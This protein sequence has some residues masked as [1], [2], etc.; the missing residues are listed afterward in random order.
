MYIV[1]SLVGVV[2]FDIKV[3]WMSLRL[4]GSQSQAD[5]FQLV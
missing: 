1:T 4:V 2:G 5:H 3:C